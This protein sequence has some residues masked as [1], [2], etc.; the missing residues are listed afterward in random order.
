MSSAD[1][2]VRSGRMSPPS[3]R[4]QDT[5]QSSR[6]RLSCLP[7]IG[8][9]LIKHRPFVGGRFGGR[10]PARP[11]CTTPR[12]GFVFFAP[13]IRSRLLADPT[14]RFPCSPAPRTPGQGT[15][16]PSMIAC[17]AHARDEP[18]APARRL[19]AQTVCKPR[20]LAF[21]TRQAIASIKA[22]FRKFAFSHS[23][24]LR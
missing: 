14:S 16:T 23:L 6:G 11:N 24:C 2:A 1:S 19:H 21:L 3:V 12:I 13:H 20:S 8:A 5:P 15:F 22:H 9:R 10:V 17:T 7:C 4:H 18:R